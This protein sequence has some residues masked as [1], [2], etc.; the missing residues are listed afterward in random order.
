MITDIFLYIIG[1]LI[2]TMTYLLRFLS[3]ASGMVWPPETLSAFQSFGNSLASIN[4]MFATYELS[5]AVSFFIQFLTY[6]FSGIL[7]IFII[8]TIRGN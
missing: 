5:I 4:F 2:S 3:P 7:I 6:L 8:K 1:V